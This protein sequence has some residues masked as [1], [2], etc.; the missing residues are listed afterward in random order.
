[1][2]VMIR[3]IS[4]HLM[5]SVAGVVWAFWRVEPVGGRYMGVRE[6][7]EVIDRVTGLVRSL[8]Y[9]ARVF[10]LS[11]QRDPG[12][13]VLR[14][15]ESVDLE[16]CPFWAQVARAQ[17]DLLS[18]M[19]VQQRTV[20]LAVPL[21]VSGARAQVSAALGSAWAEVSGLLGLRPAPV[22]AA[23]VAEFR[24]RALQ[25]VADLGGGVVLRPARAAEIVWMHQ[26]AVHRGLDEP[27]LVEAASA[28]TAYEGAVVGGV[29]R[30]PSYA[31]L[32]QV[33][34]LEGG[35]EPVGSGSEADGGPSVARARPRGGRA[36]GPSPVR[37]QWLEVECEA[38]TGYQAQLA[39]AQLPR[40]VT[41]SRADWLAQLERMPFP[42]DVVCDLRLVPAAKVEQEVA[43]KKRELVDQAEQYAAHSATGL[44]E[45]MR[46]A[47]GDLG[48]L[49]ARAA[50][51][52]V[53]VEVQSVT[54]LSVWGPDARTCEER[55]RALAGEV[56]GAGYRLVRPIGGQEKLFSL[57]L[58]GSTAAASVREFTQ[59]QL[60]EDWAMGGAFV[61]A[62]FG[63]PTGQLIG[64]SQDAGTV[65][66]VLLDVANAPRANASASFGVAGDLGGGKSV[67]LKLITS[68]VVD[69]GGRAIVI[70]RTPMR[71]WERFAR[72]AA[73]GRCQIVDA[74]RAELSI[75]P[76]RI[77]PPAV[78]AH[79]ALSYLTLQLGVGPMTAQGALL[80]RA[81]QQATSCSAPSMARVM[82]ALDEMAAEEAGPRSQE[83]GTLLDLLRIVA[84]RPLARMVFDE[85]LP[86]IDLEG[87]LGSSDFVVITT[88]GLTLPPRETVGHPELLRTQPLEALIGRAVLYLIA[89]M[90]RQVAFAQDR[91]TLVTVDE[92]YWLTSS[93]EGL[94][95]V[96]EIV[97]DGRKH[98]AG[99]GLGGHDVL[100]LGNEVIRGLLAY[101]FLAR[102]SD[103]VLAARGLE[104]LGL[105]GD[106]E[107][108]LRQVTSDLSPIGREGREG[109]MFGRDARM[110]IGRFQVVVPPLPRL[111]DGIFTTPDAPSPAPD[112]GRR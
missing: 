24:Q 27:L 40:A 73:H 91:F 15:L 89:A 20:W 30:S 105:P 74:A 35:M 78:G 50:Q 18:G 71:E 44:P 107:D 92:C 16:A 82:E 104:F 33:R 9:A 52:Q 49:G 75:D 8:P 83:A 63:D 23:E 43:K 58:P 29:L 4:G 68:G 54:V 42:V 103:P 51:S 110:Q 106:D 109:E 72:T 65:V 56:K 21:T 3:H 32:G 66:P 48:E 69:R 22:P 81:V 14:T 88:A 28:D 10:S 95:L 98:R 53:E 37:R 39:V 112:G 97:H 111:L 67:L 86:A 64:I 90:A 1:M 45:G 19:E 96:H 85:A 62:S 36:R 70:D 25:V 77:F 13:V 94:A 17:L 100:E 11:A 31:D 46:D 76:L 101:R 80:N 26:H 61:S 55:A 102:T 7:S 108:L 60:S 93:A 2:R 34:L 12:E 6:H 87:E 57:F 5:W 99:I 84:D 38:G 41:E 59:F 79:Y 47:A